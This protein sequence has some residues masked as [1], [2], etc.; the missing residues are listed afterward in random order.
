MFLK[1]YNLL[2]ALLLA[3][4]SM[5]AQQAPENYCGYTGK[6][7]W[8]AWYQQNKDKFATDRDGD[9]TWLYVPVTIHIVGNDNG[10]GF[11]PVDQAVRAIAEMNEQYTNA[12]M[13]FYLYPG[14]PFVYHSNTTWYDHDWEG[15][16]ELINENRIYGRLNAYV[17]ADP[18]GN[19]GYSWQDAIVLGK[20]CS[21][22]GNT[23]WAHEA[24]HH[25]SLPHPFY[26]WENTTWNYATPAPTQIGGHDVEKTDGSNCEYAGDGFCDTRP[27]YL[28]YRWA[29][30]GDG[31]STVVQRDPDGVEFRSDAS[32]FM[33]YAL[34]QCSGRFTPEQIAAMRANLNSQHAD[35]LQI[36]S[37]LPEIPDAA[38]VELVSPIDTQ[39]VQF[40]NANLTFKVP[41]TATIFAVEV[42]LFENFVPVIYSKSFYQPGSST[43]T[44]HIDKPLPKNRLLYWRTFAFSEWDVTQPKTNYQIGVFKTENINATNELERSVAAVLSPNPVRSGTPALLQLDAEDR[45]DAL[46]TVTDMSGRICLRQNLRIN[47]GTQ[48][49]ELPTETLGAGAYLMTLQNEKGL[50]SLRLSVVD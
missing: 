39:L 43:I 20:G 33:G 7:P 16:S 15:G 19:C 21:G 42:G 45:Q 9:T 41:P 28:N 2:F 18:A 6:S 5:Q 29:C 31:E 4:V 44:V 38:Q 8:L 49:I 32:L 30:N 11:Y 34:D 23:T 24:G 50:Y 10:V 3:S 35:Y 37:P 17:V 13:R 46:I 40:D 36:T 1:N 25:F 48:Q 14:E 47:A 22:A 27:D 26:G 12:H